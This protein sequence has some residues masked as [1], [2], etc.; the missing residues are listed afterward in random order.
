MNPMVN[1]VIRFNQQVL[2]IQPRE[3]G[4]MVEG[5]ANATVK[6]LVEESQEFADAYHDQDILG[7]VDAL[8]DS[9]Y[10]AI[11]GLYKMGLSGVQIDAAFEAVHQCNMKKKLG[12]V[13]KR[14]NPLGDAVKPQDWSGPE[15]ALAE[16][17]GV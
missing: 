9:I 13:E 7:Q 2:D 5:E 16:I 11:G 14:N 15:E 12:I 8:I 10:F 3:L 4:V 6:A 1:S 17:L